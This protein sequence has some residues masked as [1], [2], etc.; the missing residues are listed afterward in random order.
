MDSFRSKLVRSL[1]RNPQIS[2][3]SL[4][5]RFHAEACRSTVLD[6]AFQIPT[7][8]NC[9]FGLVHGQFPD[10]A[11]SPDDESGSVVP[12]TATE[13]KLTV[14]VHANAASPPAG[15]TP[16]PRRNLAVAVMQKPFPSDTKL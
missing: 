1:L 3:K 9:S 10:E 5:K 4:Q 16:S 8:E 6:Q 13:T 2:K 11:A 15:D 12:D 7:S 14:P